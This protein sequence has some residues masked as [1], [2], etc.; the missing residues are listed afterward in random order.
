M[1]SL[2]E[3]KSII[4]IAIDTLNNEL[5]N[6]NDC[7][8]NYVPKV[9]KEAFKQKLEKML[10]YIQANNLPEKSQRNFGL[11]R[12]VVDSMPFNSALGKQIV[13]AE[14]AFIDISD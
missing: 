10:F 11:S 9:Q 5:S 4:Q 1:N 3:A 7:K 12:S 8:L 14:K 6:C 2:L 13:E